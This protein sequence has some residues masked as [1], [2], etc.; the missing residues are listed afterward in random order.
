MDIFINA[1]YL[2]GAKENGCWG[3][4]LLCTWRFEGHWEGLSSPVIQRG[5]LWRIS[6]EG[7]RGT[8]WKGLCTAVWLWFLSCLPQ[9]LPQP[10]AFSLQPHRAPIP[11]V[12]SYQGSGCRDLLILRGNQPHFI[13]KTKS[14]W[15]QF[16]RMLPKRHMFW[17]KT[18][19]VIH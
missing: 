15:P 4:K 11:S 19:A 9:M 1:L 17:E 6:K 13:W 16:S 14:P 5:V 8:F 2:P 10:R 3:P 7:A 12:A 18:Q